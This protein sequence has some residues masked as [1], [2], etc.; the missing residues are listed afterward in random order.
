MRILRFDAASPHYWQTFIANGQGWHK[1]SYAEQ[2]A[3][4]DYDA[5]KCPAAFVG[6]T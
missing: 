6:A 1:K 4:F 2:R 3:T 5:F